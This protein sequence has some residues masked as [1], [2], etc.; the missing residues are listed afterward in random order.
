MRSKPPT[1]FGCTCTGCPGMR[2][3]LA[4]IQELEQRINADT[5]HSA[6]AAARLE[7]KVDD[8]LAKI[9]PEAPKP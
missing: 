3:A 4:F 6:N 2:A 5:H 9:D 7:R 1:D 8:V